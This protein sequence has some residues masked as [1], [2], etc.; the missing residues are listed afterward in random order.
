MT[1][2]LLDVITLV[3]S[4]KRFPLEL[5]GFMASGQV[6]VVH[7]FRTGM[8]C[9]RA[10]TLDD[11][12]TRRLVLVDSVISDISPANLCDALRLAHPDL[13]ILMVIPRNNAEEIQ[14]AMLAGAKATIA[15][16]ASPAELSQLL[17]RVVEAC[18]THPSGGSGHAA[19]EG[20]SSYLQQASTAQQA[21]IVPLIGARGG[22]GRSTTSSMLAYLAAEAH[23]DTALIDFDLQFGDLSFLF[24]STGRQDFTQGKRGAHADLYSDG[25]AADDLQRF[26][27]EAARGGQPGQA[28]KSL[29][30]FSK[31]LTPHLHLYAPRSAPEKT[32]LLAQLL[33]A[34]LDNLRYEHELIVVN[35]G[36]Y[37]TLFHSEL[38]EQSDLALC[39][40]DQS[41]VGV[42]AT[43]ELRELC[44]RIGVPSSRLV[45]VMN[46]VREGGIDR[47][48]AAEVLG[49]EKVFSIADAGSK[50]VDLFDSGNLEQILQEGSYMAG[51]YPIL[52]E[53]AVR[54][55]LRIHDTVSLRYTMRREAG[56]RLLSGTRDPG[57]RSREARGVRQLIAAGRKGL[58]SRA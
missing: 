8:E 16:D 55:D 52:D 1:T 43:L 6:R 20:R 13:A 9:L 26:L 15:R 14:R 5:S 53:L 42:R 46:R 2:A 19:G 28:S 51:L 22:A 30:K 3:T 34:A 39:V 31:Q 32:E 17:D 23:I 7:T 36:A 49:A 29:R 45:F 54:S 10:L 40:F 21:V 25:Q 11:S 57:A 27:E 4:D 41:I 48:S 56:T 50:L 38:L 33:P 37:W 18:I 47:K 12:A 44:R 58:L 24:G 35:T